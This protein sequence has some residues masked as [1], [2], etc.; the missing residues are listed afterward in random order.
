M[1]Q[2]KTLVVIGAGPGLGASVARIFAKNGYRTVLVARR[3]ES[4]D[5][6]IATLRDEGI[7]AEGYVASVTDS[8]ALENVL[9]AVI[10]KFGRV[11]A[12]EYSPFDMTFIAPSDVTAAIAR[13]AVEF[14][15]IGAVTAVQKV[16]PGMREAG[17]GIILLTTGRSALLPLKLLG[18]LGLGASALRHYAYSLNEELKPAGIYAGTIAQFNVIT[19]EVA[20]RMAASYWDMSN[21]RDRVEEI[22][23]AGEVEGPVKEISRLAQKH[24]PFDLPTDDASTQSK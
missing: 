22:D 18:A 23:G 9:D 8:P 24:A 20:D 5:R 2:L 13:Q 12:I 14:Q 11:D 16:L 21:K 7:E 17:D 1:N 19:S 10:A 6:L 4:V 3:K 15:L